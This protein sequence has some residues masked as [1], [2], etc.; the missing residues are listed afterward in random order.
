MATRTIGHGPIGLGLGWLVVDRLLRHFSPGWAGGPNIGGGMFLLA[1]YAVILV[2]LVFL[3]ASLLP[4]SRTPPSRTPSS[5]RVGRLSLLPWIVNAVLL[6][7]VAAGPFVLPSQDPRDRI[8]GRMGVTVDAAGNPVL[9]LEI[10]RDAVQ[11][12]SLVGPNVNSRNESFALLVAPAPVTRTLLLDPLRPPDGWT[13][14]PDALPY[15]SQPDLLHISSAHG[16]DGSLSQVSFTRTSLAGLDPQTVQYS[17]WDSP[18]RRTV[19]ERVPMA[20]FH[21]LVCDPLLRN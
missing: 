7:V 4:R 2:G 10:C 20:D 14:V 6:A 3:V 21:A 5:S 9:V 19:D 13:G 8:A 17:T 18:A 11:R 12:V 1:A 16:E 15:T